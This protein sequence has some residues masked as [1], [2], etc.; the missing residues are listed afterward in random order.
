MGDMQPA[1]T[2]ILTFGGI[3]IVKVVGQAVNLAVLVEVFG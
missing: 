1:F 3:H 2:I